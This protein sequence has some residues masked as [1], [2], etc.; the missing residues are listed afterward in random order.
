MKIT[1]NDNKIFT[2]KLSSDKKVYGKVEN[3]NMLDMPEYSSAISSY[4]KALISRPDNTMPLNS[5]DGMYK[6]Q[7]IL[8]YVS[9]IR[10]DETISIIDAI[11]MIDPLDIKPE[12]KT[13]YIL[14]ATYDD[15]KKETVINKQALKIVELS[16]HLGLTN[17]EYL[18]AIRHGIDDEGRTFDID[19]FK[20][21]CLVN[22]APR[23][24]S[25]TPKKTVSRK[26]SVREARNYR[27]QELQSYFGKNTQIEKTQ[28]NYS[29]SE[30]ELFTPLSEKRQ[31]LITDLEQL[32]D[33]KEI[34]DS[35]HTKMKE[36]IENNDFDLKKV[37]H[38]HYQ[39]LNL[40]STLDEVKE[41]YPEIKFSDAPTIKGN[42]PAKSINKRLLQ[43]GYDKVSIDIL[44]RLYLGL[45]TRSNMEINLKTSMPT[46]MACLRKAGFEYSEPS[47][48][49]K[50]F[51]M[52]GEEIT[53]T[54]ESL[55]DSD[56][57][58]LEDLAKKNAVRNSAVWADFH[59][60]TNGTWYPVR[61]IKGNNINK[62]PNLT[63]PKLVDAYLFALYKNNKDRK[64]E[65]NPLAKY[66]DNT[67]LT[68]PMR[69]IINRTYAFQT[70]EKP[71]EF[72][73]PEF[74]EFKSQFDKEAMCKSFENLKKRYTNSF[75]AKYWT[76][77]RRNKLKDELQN[78]YDL[79]FEK[80]RF[81]AP[82]QH[83]KATQKDV[84]ALIEIDAN[85]PSEPQ[86]PDTDMRT[87]KFLTSIIKNENLKV[88]CNSCISNPKMI[89]TD[90]FNQNYNV[91]R[92]SYNKDTKT[93]DED[94]ATVLLDLHDQFYMQKA[95]NNTDIENVDDFI[96]NSLAAYTDEN[97]VVDYKKMLKTSQQPNE[98]K[99]HPEY[100]V[101][102][103]EKMHPSDE[104]NSKYINKINEW[105]DL[106]DQEKNLSNFV[107][108]F[109]ISDPRGAKFIEAFIEN[110]YK[111][112]DTKFHAKGKQGT[113][114]EKQER[115]VILDK[116]A[117]KAILS[118]TNFPKNAEMLC[119][120]ENAMHHLVGPNNQAGIKRVNYDSRYQWEVKIN[121]SPSRIMSADC[122]DPL[123]FDTFIIEGLHSNKK[124]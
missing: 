42:E 10:P 82:N 79:I 80:L 54:Y 121:G 105:V 113:P 24:Y 122:K 100:L 17:K 92:Q 73:S 15:D 90:Y 99:K 107:K 124:F 19:K 81:S 123:T 18:D 57:K 38:K 89:D 109:N 112:S 119:S 77:E 21:Q 20:S 59:D 67:F 55:K 106:D 58:Y 52:K 36:S 76:E 97:G 1:D 23:R 49:L 45:E 44:Q 95:Y 69:I 116:K 65:K 16:H 62:D 46:N 72:S 96:K 35:L 118:Y 7:D 53:K 39:Y 29:C 66:D 3:A 111:N 114:I 60:M 6:F 102:T 5:P 70:G 47:E 71:K 31:E 13:Q 11:E 30:K 12:D 85:E 33:S 94:K 34:P 103:L 98:G 63:T 14:T 43:E 93:L 61:L 64:H 104:L 74:Q 26:Y 108:I 87:F 88:R 51:L 9:G 115:D 117:K 86:I 8:S 78:S 41:F 37:H 120:F 2:T 101:E 22:G 91:L 40:C 110:E 56:D 28:T 48:N 32:K 25:S 4:G 83:K 84:N 75:F 50:K 27:K 68:P